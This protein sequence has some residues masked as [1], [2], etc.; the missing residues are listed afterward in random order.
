MMNEEMQECQDNG[1]QQNLATSERGNIG[2]RGLGFPGDFK[3]THD[4]L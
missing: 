4:S 3:T 1:C 2:V